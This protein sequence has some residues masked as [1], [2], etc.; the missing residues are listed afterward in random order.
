MYEVVYKFNARFYKGWFSLS[1]W[2]EWMEKNIG[3]T[4]VFPD[5]ETIASRKY[6]SSQEY[7]KKYMYDVGTLISDLILCHGAHIIFGIPEKWYELE[8][9]KK[10]LGRSLKRTTK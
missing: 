7:T 2:T 3:K 9:I 1:E 6:M 4:G 8:E 5:I 10:E